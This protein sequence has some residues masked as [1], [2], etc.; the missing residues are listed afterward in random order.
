MNLQ[1]KVIVIT[2]AGSG[3][4][5]EIALRLSKEK[6]KLALISLHEE[7]LNEVAKECK[8]YG[9]VDVKIYAV[10]ITDTSK[11]EDTAFNI[12]SDF[13][14]VDVL[15]NN[16]GVWQKL[17]P[18]YEI[19]SKTINRVINTNL[20]ALIHMTRLFI[21]TLMDRDEAAIINISSKS[22]VTVQPGQSV[23]SASKYGVRGFTD[24]LRVDL[25][26]TNVRVT[27]IYQG[28]TN[29]K[30]FEKAGENIITDN[31]INPSDLAD[32]VAYILKQPPNIWI[33]DIRI[34]Y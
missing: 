7:K 2:G 17:Q 15:I 18:F 29:T 31:F 5:K 1:K 6:A 30:L 16:A 4:G 33:N 27:G 8:D 11:L 20:S 10:D 13:K 34:D 22:G 25:K 9:A 28:G 24:V 14:H 26:D 32:V 12:L 23:Y 19:D 3:I 21:D